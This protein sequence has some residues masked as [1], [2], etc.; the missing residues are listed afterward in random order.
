M[1]PSGPVNFA[2]SPLRHDRYPGGMSLLPAP[3]DLAIGFAHPAYRL[4]EEFLSRRNDI[5]TREARSELD[6]RAMLGEVDVLVVSGLWRN[7]MISEAS[8]LRFIQS[9]S[10]GVNMF[11]PS[12]LSAAGI[13]LASAQ[14][15]NAAAVAEHA[16]ALVLSLHRH[17]HL[18]RDRQARSEWRGMIGDPAL[19]ERQLG[20]RTLLVV[21][22]GEIGQ[23]L[24]RLAKAFGM[25]VVGLRRNARPVPDA[26][27]EVARIGE[28][29]AF[30]PEADIVALTC[31]LTSE[32][33]GLIG[34]AELAAMKP[35]AMLVNVARGPVV[36]EPALVEA[37][38]AGR[39]AAA[40]L[41][42][43]HEEPLPAASPFWAMPNVIVTPHSAGE[44]AIY[45]RA[46]IDILE[47]NL[48]RLWRGEA[49]LRNQV[50]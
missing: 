46:V 1:P 7:D 21:G 27:D 6:L 38:R 10:A 2:L 43:F 35:G 39:P 41:D 4:R 8:R 34:A 37:L 24:G 9:V 3:R 20:G 33:A 17:L 15:G 50:A 32:T 18:A 49:A 14:G 47:D 12:A 44:T 23:R 36:D 29:H 31:P 28:L 22:F 45:E 11:D 25:R 5:L 26:A 48:G 16:M 42:V 19:R 30:L 13:R 40:A